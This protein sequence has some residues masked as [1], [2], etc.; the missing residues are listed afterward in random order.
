M[1]KNLNIEINYGVEITVLQV[2]NI[3][4]CGLRY[5]TKTNYHILSLP[6]Y[7]FPHILTFLFTMCFIING[8]HNLI[9][10]KFSFLVIYKIRAHFITGS[11]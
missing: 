6:R 7:I 5:Q 9:G 8:I 11:I 10:S 1:I 3:S 2:T 4:A